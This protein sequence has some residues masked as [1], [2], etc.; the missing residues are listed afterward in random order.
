[1][2]LE[3]LNPTAAN[4]TQRRQVLEH[5]GSRCLYTV[6]LKLESVQKNFQIVYFY[7]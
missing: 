4:I 1:M 3:K 5:S 2:S 6:Q 7:Q